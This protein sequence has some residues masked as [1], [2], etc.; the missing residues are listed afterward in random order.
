MATGCVVPEVV[1]R[2]IPGTIGGTVSGLVGGGLVLTA[3]GAEDLSISG[4][5]AFAFLT[6]M[7]RGESYV[8]MV[9]RQPSG[10]AQ[11]CSIEHGSG[12]AGERVVTDIKVRCSVSAFEVGGTVTGLAGRGLVLHSGAG[13][14]VS[15]DADGAFTFP[16]P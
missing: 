7:Q 11:I 1:Y 2:E 10:P 6:P 9:K 16:T 15:V 5:G 3:N 14:R 12:T 13:E 8:V 4:D